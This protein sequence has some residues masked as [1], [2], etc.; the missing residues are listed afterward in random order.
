M[1]MATPL[2]IVFLLLC[3]SL[4]VTVS[5]NLYNDFEITWGN[6]RAKLL[7]NGQQL[8]LTLDR[9]SGN[10]YLFGKFDFHAIKLCY[11]NY[12]YSNRY[13]SFSPLTPSMLRPSYSFLA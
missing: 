1:D 9:T 3:P 11:I 13:A 7:D 4:L 5:A 2:L 12:A 6:D 10:I 8:Q